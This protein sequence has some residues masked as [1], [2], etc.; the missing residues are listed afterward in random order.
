MPTDACITVLDL[1][2]DTLYWTADNDVVGVDINDPSTFHHEEIV[3]EGEIFGD[4]RAASAA[5][6][7]DRESSGSI[8]SF[9]K[10]ELRTSNVSSDA[11]EYSAGELMA[12]KI[13]VPLV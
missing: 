6:S 10:Q 12:G 2:G 5:S 9:Y 13:C 7:S 3:G 4:A 1:E 8:L 11:Q